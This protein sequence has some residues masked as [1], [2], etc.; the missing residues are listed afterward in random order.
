MF[1]NT[2]QYPRTLNKLCSNMEQL[3]GS[4]DS[5]EA[6]KIALLLFQQPL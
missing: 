2:I 3:L 5:E 6:M 1:V 4:E